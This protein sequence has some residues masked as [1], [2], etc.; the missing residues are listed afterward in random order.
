[1]KSDRKR[2]VKNE[3]KESKKENPA[4]FLT[5]AQLANHSVKSV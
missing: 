5:S 4:N 2:C 3:K 1:M